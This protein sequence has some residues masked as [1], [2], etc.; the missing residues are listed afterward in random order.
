MEEISEKSRKSLDEQAADIASQ[1][2]IPMG[3]M[4]ME[5]ST[6]GKFGAPK[7]FH[8][9]NFKTEDLVGLALEDEDKVQEAAAEML[10]G[11]IWEKDVDV[12]K[13]HTK[14]VVE[15][16]LRLYKRYYQSVL[17]NLPWELTDED[18]DV[19]ATEEGG[20]DSDAYRRRIDA[21]RRGEEK[22][23]FD[24]DLKKVEFYDIPDNV[25]GTVRATSKDPETGENFV[26]EY[27]YPRYGDTILL[28][29]FINDIPEIKEG[30]KRFAAI[31]E[32]VKFR[33]KMEQAWR[34]GENIPLERIP[35]FTQKDMEAFNEFQKK[36]AVFATRAVKALHLKS[37]DGID[38]SNL[39]LDKKLA[40]ADDPRL[41]HTT[42]EQVN[43][44]YEDMKIG[45]NEDV[46]VLDPYTRR[47]TKIHYTFRLFTILQTIRDNKPDGTTIEFV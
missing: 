14:E 9:R 34:E 10:Q 35:K 30:E 39:P 3:Y 7:V 23:F 32:N 8:I 46:T 24:I 18:R 33:Q 26:V 27:T 40:Y 19:I 43:K 6:K 41:N 47:L 28:K 44:L 16:F 45:P 38:V 12:L 21:I 4:T 11:L 42:F 1:K 13:F 20:K 25:T 5:L 2:K 37:I 29:K 22:Q 31:T 15:T 36:K 17:K